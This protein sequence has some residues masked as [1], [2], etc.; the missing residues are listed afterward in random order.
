MRPHF[1]SPLAKYLDS[2]MS[3]VEGSP[4]STAKHRE[5]VCVSIDSWA[6]SP[7]LSLDEI[8]RAG[9]GG[10]RDLES[11]KVGRSTLV[12]KVGIANGL[13]AH[14]AA[15]GVAMKPLPVPKLTDRYIPYAF[16]D[17]EI[18]SLVGMAD[19]MRPF[20]KTSLRWSL[21][22][23]PVVLRL[24]AFCGM[25][26]GETLALLTDDVDLEEATLI[27]RKTKRSKERIV[28]M[29]TGMAAIM[30][31]YSMKVKPMVGG[32]FFPGRTKSDHLTEDRVQA[33]FNGSKSLLGIGPKGL[34][35]HERGACP[36]C[37]RHWFALSSLRKAGSEGMPPESS[38]PYLSYYLGH[39]R[40]EETEKYLK[41]SPECFPEM[42]DSLEGCLSSVMGG[43]L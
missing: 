5:S 21:L 39:H 4:Y 1:V 14:M 19:S 31:S 35:R 41:F 27:L 28:P 8:C 40:F 32:F 15:S 26:L 2:F 37:L 20:G 25:R 12:G 22:E 9:L 11:G 43:T 3:M 38:V 42:S 36:H 30:R 34:G 18:A 6:L 33:I 17:A 7:R 23:W 29:A 24:M 16:S 10:W 13:A